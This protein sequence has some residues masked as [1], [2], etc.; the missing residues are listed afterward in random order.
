MFI[1]KEGVLIK[2]PLLL[3][4]GSSEKDSAEFAERI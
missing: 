4:Q 2:L 1:I 3:S